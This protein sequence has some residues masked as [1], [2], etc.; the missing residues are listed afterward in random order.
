MPLLLLPARY[1]AG[2]GGAAPQTRFFNQG[3]AP[4]LHTKTLGETPCTP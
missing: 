4:Y 2:L 1:E 3:I